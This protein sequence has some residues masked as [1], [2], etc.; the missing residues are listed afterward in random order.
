MKAIIILPLLLIIIA[1]NGLKLMFDVDDRS[2]GIYIYM[3]AVGLIFFMCDSEYDG[4]DVME[5][6]W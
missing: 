2:D 1:I 5:W 3:P 6:M 4:V